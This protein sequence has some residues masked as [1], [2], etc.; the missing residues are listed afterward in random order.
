MAHTFHSG[1][2]L[3][4]RVHSTSTRLSSL[5]LNEKDY[6]LKLLRYKGEVCT[7]SEISL[8][9]AALYKK[10]RFHL[11]VLFLLKCFFFFVNSHLHNLYLAVNQGPQKTGISMQQ[12]LKEHFK[13]GLHRDCQTFYLEKLSPSLLGELYIQK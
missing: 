11:N 1:C 12:N 8:I 9:R 6:F 2:S 13:F 5:S 3:F 10:W 4:L 7:Q